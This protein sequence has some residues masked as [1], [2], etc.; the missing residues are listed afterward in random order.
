MVPRSRRYGRAA[1]V[2]FE[3]SEMLAAPGSASPAGSANAIQTDQIGDTSNTDQDESEASEDGA[4]DRQVN[5]HDARKEQKSGP[6]QPEP[7]NNP[8]SRSLNAI[9]WN[10]NPQTA[11]VK[12]VLFRRV[13]GRARTRCLLVASVRVGCWGKSYAAAGATLTSNPRASILRWSRFA[14]TAGSC[15]SSKNRAPG[16]S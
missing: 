12:C 14:S 8:Q 2:V 3:V 7:C 6:H 13:A 1:C 10:M 4:V 11:G 5:E 16:S 15:R 9:L